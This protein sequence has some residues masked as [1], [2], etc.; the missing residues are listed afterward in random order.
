MRILKSP[1][2]QLPFFLILGGIL[3]MILRYDVMWDFANYHYYNPWAFLN[4]R[5]MYDIAPAG[6]NTF[7]NPLPDIPLYL[8]IKYFND[9]PNVIH[10]M[11]GL[12]L[13][14][15]MYVFFLLLKL[16]FD[17]NTLKGKI[18]ILLAFLVGMTNWSLFFQIGSSTN[19]IPLA[20]LETWAFYIL[21]KAIFYAEENKETKINHFLLSGFILGSAMGL[22]LTAVIYCVSIG[23][24]LL[25]FYKYVPQ[26]KK[27]IP[28]FILGGLLGFLTFYGFWGYILWENFQNPFFPFAN[29]IFKSEWFPTENY[30]DMR[31]D[32]QSV[33]EY[34]LNRFYLI[35][36][37]V[38]GY[39][40][41]VHFIFIWGAIC[42]EGI[43][44]F[45]SGSCFFDKKYFLLL[46]LFILGYIFWSILFGIQRYTI[47]LNFIGAIIIIKSLK[48]YQPKSEFGEILYSSALI[49][50]F[51]IILSVPYYS[52]EA[53][54]RS[55][56]KQKDIYI[57]YHLL[58]NEKI[59]NR[60]Y[61]FKKYTNMQPIN[62]SDNTLVLIYSR[63]AAAFLPIISKNSNVRGLSF[64]D[65]EYNG[66]NDGKVF[67]QG[68]W[69]K[70]KE[71]IIQNHKGVKVVLV[72]ENTQSAMVQNRDY[73][74]DNPYVPNMKCRIVDNNMAN[75]SLCF[76]AENEKEIFGDIK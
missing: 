58:R 35:R 21:I 65:F 31:E 41:N 56:E 12:W 19:E 43:K 49:I 63:P 29:G 55:N 38:E 8:M 3:S 7:F 24:T 23:G 40:I 70:I 37:T 57:T 5:F 26:A 33:S 45:F 28:F 60:I 52:E 39:F 59:S 44:K 18:C 30:R 16:Y 11:Q 73:L 6:V 15:L 48:C 69:K 47:F 71:D 75:W 9:Y 34:I 68:K 50:F 13:G 36:E 62:L 1:Y 10:F 74:E 14:G 2:F 20:F 54:Q 61:G 64:T 67:N 27:N 22:K 66:V 4:G 17:I 51:Y 72:A 32:C 25:C 53:E 42:I 46:C 76:S